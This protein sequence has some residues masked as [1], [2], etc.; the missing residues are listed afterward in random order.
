MT[1]EYLRTVRHVQIK[2]LGLRGKISKENSE[3]R[4][5]SVNLRD[6][7]INESDIENYTSLM[8]TTVDDLVKASAELNQLAEV[9]NDLRYAET[10]RK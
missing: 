5:I 9:Y 6:D 10:H 3:L 4:K 7:D 8:K 2:M 1:D